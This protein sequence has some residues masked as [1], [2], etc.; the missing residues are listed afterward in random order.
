MDEDTTRQNGALGLDVAA[1]CGLL[2]KGTHGQWYLSDHADAR[3]VYFVGDEKTASLFEKCIHN[4]EN[5]PAV[6]TDAD[7][8]AELDM[9]VNTMKKMI[10]KPGDWHAG[11]T[12]LQSIMTTFWD[13]F[14]EP[15]VRK[16]G[17]KRVRQDCR[18]CYFQA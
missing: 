4:L 5:N 9:L 11:L 2:V 16:L 17:W 6:S 14:L 13:S 1:K 8:F 15:L 12:M 18:D 7:K 3:R 10:V